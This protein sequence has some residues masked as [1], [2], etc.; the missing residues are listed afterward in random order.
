MYVHVSRAGGAHLS[1]DASRGGSKEKQK[2][3]T[4]PLHMIFLMTTPFC[5]L[6]LIHRWP[7]SRCHCLLW[8]HEPRRN[9]WAT[10]DTEPPQ[11]WTET[12]KQGR[13]IPW[14]LAFE[15]TMSFTAGHAD[16]GGKDSVRRFHPRYCPRKFLI[17]PPFSI[18]FFFLA[19]TIKWLYFLNFIWIEWFTKLKCWGFLHLM[20]KSKIFSA[21]LKIIY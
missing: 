6:Y 8:Q 21:H 16:M 3:C 13:Q 5:C 4:P 9:S 20:L 2:G 19:L 7:D 12:T 11:G 17:H 14:L 10:E 18:V 15:H 1:L